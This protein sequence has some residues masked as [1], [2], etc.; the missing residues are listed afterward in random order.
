MKTGVY[1]IT[2]KID[3]KCY[4]GSAATS[5]KRRISSHR[6][7]L[8]KGTHH[9]PHLQNAWNKYG[10]EAFEVGVLTYCDAASCVELEQIYIDMHDPE[11]NVC[12]VAGSTLG[13]RHTSESKKKMADASRGNKNCVG[14]VLSKETKQ[15]IG[16]ANKGSKHTLAARQKMSKSRKGKRVGS[17]NPHYGKGHEQSGEKSVNARL[18]NDQAN[19][20]RQLVADGMTQ[21]DAAIRMGVSRATMSRIINGLRYVS[22]VF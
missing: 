6:H 18:T 15:K 20:A 10:A 17:S 3:G 5:F 14:R 11:Y 9:S 7:H 4:I 19:Y 16:N 1:I 8:N 12:K 22:E 2:N 21:K 13:F